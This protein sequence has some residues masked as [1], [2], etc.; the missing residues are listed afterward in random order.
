MHEGSDEY[1]KQT[2]NRIYNSP[3]VTLQIYNIFLK[4]IEENGILFGIYRV[5]SSSVCTEQCTPYALGSYSPVPE[6]SS[7]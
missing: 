3:H 7:S 2:D 1:K 6:M 5:E 4:K